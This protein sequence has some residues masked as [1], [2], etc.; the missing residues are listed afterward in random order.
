ME[1][2]NEPGWLQQVREMI[3]VAN[4]PPGALEL[5]YKWDGESQWWMVDTLRSGSGINIATE[6][7]FMKRFS[8]HKMRKVAIYD[9]R[10]SRISFYAMQAY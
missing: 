6:W 2:C 5:V 4:I 9:V 8:R 3:G 7:L 10:E 1:Q